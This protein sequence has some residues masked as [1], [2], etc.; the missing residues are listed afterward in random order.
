[1]DNIFPIPNR[2]FYSSPCI[3]HRMF[4]SYLKTR[5][6][7]TRSQKQ[8]RPKKK[9]WSGELSAASSLK[10]ATTSYRTELRAKSSKL[11]ALSFTLFLFSETFH[12]IE[13]NDLRNK[14]MDR[15]VTF[16]KGI[17]ALMNCSMLS[18]LICHAGV[19]M[20][21]SIPKVCRKF[22]TSII[23]PKIST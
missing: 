10:E 22:V 13:A 17:G 7:S 20:G 9:E 16:W 5:T 6:F 4:I 3:T 21:R 1:M 19:K 18:K 11:F 15:S 8:L 2:W 12:R 14:D 23:F